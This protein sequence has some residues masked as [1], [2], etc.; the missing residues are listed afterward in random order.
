MNTTKQQ[1]S[2][3]KVGA[4]KLSKMGLS[5]VLALTLVSPP[6]AYGFD[7]FVPSAGMSSA[8]ALVGQIQQ[9]GNGPFR[10]QLD[11]GVALCG[12]GVSGNTWGEI[13]V[14]LNP[15][16]GIPVTAEAMKAMISTLTAAKLAGRRVWIATTNNSSAAGLGVGYGCRVEVVTMM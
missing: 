6:V 9:N 7:M 10:F 11:G 12:T 13:A 2:A 4:T 1:V 5:A 14:N 8:G 15:S 3:M 16:S